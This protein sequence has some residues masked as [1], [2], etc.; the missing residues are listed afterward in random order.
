MDDLQ[1]EAKLWE[2]IEGLASLRV[3]LSQTD[4]LSDRALYTLCWHDLLREAVKDLPPDD[5]A[6]WHID[7]QLTETD[8]L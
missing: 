2:T 5:S 8:A 3:F 4:H 7:D 6:A 1:L